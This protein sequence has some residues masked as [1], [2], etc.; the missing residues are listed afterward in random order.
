MSCSPHVFS[1]KVSMFL[2]IKDSA[3][4]HSV[5]A[6]G[7]FFKILLHDRKIQPVSDSEATLI[8]SKYGHL[9]SAKGAHLWRCISVKIKNIAHPAVATFLLQEAIF[10]PKPATN[11]I[12]EWLALANEGVL[13]CT[14][15]GEA[16]VSIGEDAISNEGAND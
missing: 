10:I 15:F 1:C 11:L 9:C 8:S 6:F 12:N 14:G 2:V 5:F 16:G 3:H 4:F 7:S 13:T